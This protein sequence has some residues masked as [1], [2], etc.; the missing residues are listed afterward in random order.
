MNYISILLDDE[1]YFLCYTDLKTV[2][3][4]DDDGYDELSRVMWRLHFTTERVVTGIVNGVY[5]LPQDF[6]LQ[7]NDSIESVP[8][9]VRKRGRRKLTLRMQNQSAL[10]NSATFQ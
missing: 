3:N 10:K 4:N 6:Q 5:N 8:S 2:M 7:L 1:S 9:R